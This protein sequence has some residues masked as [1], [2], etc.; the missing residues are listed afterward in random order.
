MQSQISHILQANPPK[1]GDAHSFHLYSPS[2]TKD[3]QIKINGG[4][5]VNQRWHVSSGLMQIY[6]TINLITIG[7][8]KR[9]ARFH[10]EVVKV[11]VTHPSAIVK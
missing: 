10:G 6:E 8:I 5:H 2:G 11:A 3:K 9:F 4:S 7:L 1:E